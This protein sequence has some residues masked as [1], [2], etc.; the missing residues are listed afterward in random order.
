MINVTITG[1]GSVTV[2]DLICG[3]Y[4]VEQQNGWSWRYGDGSQT[5]EVIEGNN[6]DVTFSADAEKEY[7]LNG[8]SDV[9]SNRKG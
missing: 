3:A 5:A 4:T 9:V 1:S 8:S 7:W 2:H 6:V